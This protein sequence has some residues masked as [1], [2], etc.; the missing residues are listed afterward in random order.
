MDQPVRRLTT[1]WAG[2]DGRVVAVEEGAYGAAKQLLVAVTSE[3]TGKS[4][5]L[6]AKGKKCRLN[7]VVLERFN[8]K[9]PVV[10][11][12]AVD[13]DESKFV[14]TNGDTVS[15]SNINMDNVKIFSRE[16][17]NCLAA[18][19]FRDC[20][21]CAKG[22]GKLT[23][24]KQDPVF[25]AENNMLIVA[26]V[27]TAGESMEFLRCT[28]SLGLRSIRRVTRLDRQEARVWVV[29]GGNNL[30]VGHAFQ[31]NWRAAL[32]RDVVAVIG[33]LG[34]LNRVEALNELLA[35]QILEAD[36][37]GRWWDA[38]QDD[39]RSRGGWGFLWPVGSIGRQGFRRDV[40]VI[41]FNDGWGQRRGGGSTRFGILGLDW[42]DIVQG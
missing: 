13:K 16:P 4:A 24:V 11:G 31:F 28:C 20:S 36:G 1:G 40:V 33:T 34:V 5:G 19:C 25:C 9:H 10:A 15:K 21:I 22:E 26:K 29:E 23:G 7:V 18:G 17:I 39:R 27:A 14:P 42:L 35:C 2:R 6:V 37:I 8:T 3:L 41:S 30:L 12:G 38:G 32:G